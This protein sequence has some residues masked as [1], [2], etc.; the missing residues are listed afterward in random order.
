MRR[1]G[2]ELLRGTVL[3]GTPLTRRLRAALVAAQLAMAV[4]LLTGTGLLARSVGELLAEDGGFQPERV[5]TARLMLGDSRFLDDASQTEF[6]NRLLTRVRAL[7]MVEAAGVGSTLPPIDAPTL[8]LRYRNDT[9]D[10]VIRLSFGAVTSGFF[11]ALGTPLRAGRRFAERDELAELGGAILSESTARFMF[12]DEDP[13]GRHPDFSVSAMAITRDTP[14][15]GVV[16]DMKYQGLDAP[17]T[18]AIYVPWQRR[19]MGLSHLVVRTTGDPAALVPT[20]RDLIMQ[21]NQ[22][23]PLPDV[24]T[25]DDHIAGSIAGRRLQLVPAVAALAL[26]VAMVGLFG[27]LG[28]AVTERRQELS[29]RAAVGASPARLVRLVLRSSLAVTAL[30]LTVG[31]AAAAT[32]RGLSSLLYGV[33]PYDPL[34][35]AVVAGAVLV[36]ALTA[37]II[38]A[39]RVARLDPLIALKGE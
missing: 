15:I 30:G 10:D 5:V 6:V 31:L 27:T 38:P 26:A 8:N 19:P 25:L 7:P 17:S 22:T 2:A 24:R 34:T 9:R 20:L 23:L 36:A 13:V 39:R 37:S 14:I 4:V 1:P 11:D 29:I 33:S 32:G 12:A 16:D 18:G 35:F 21:L 28:R 3:T